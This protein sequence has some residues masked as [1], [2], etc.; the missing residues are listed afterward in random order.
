MGNMDCKRLFMLDFSKRKE[1]L[2]TFQYTCLF[3]SLHLLYLLME[4][5]DLL[6]IYTIIFPHPKSCNYFIPKTSIALFI[7]NFCMDR[8]QMNHK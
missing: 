4:P 6:V 3:I 2:N 5:R 1:K 7:P 8:A